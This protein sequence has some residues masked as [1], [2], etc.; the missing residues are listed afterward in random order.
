MKL[1]K[2]IIGAADFTFDYFVEG[3]FI[4]Y[5]CPTCSA[6]QEFPLKMYDSGQL[7]ETLE[8]DLVNELLEKGIIHVNNKTQEWNACLSN[9]VLWNVDALFE[10]IDC[11]DCGHR[12]MAIFGMAE[13]QP[14]REQVQFKGIWSL[15]H[16]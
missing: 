1:G 4:G 10:F 16:R 3:G 14:G 9:Y 6:K 13:L 2:R 12:S 15:T 7:V 11:L 5:S 8:A